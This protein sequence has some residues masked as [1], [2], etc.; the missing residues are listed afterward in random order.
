MYIVHPIDL[1]WIFDEM[2]FILKKKQKKQNIRISIIRGHMWAIRK[3]RWV[4]G[5]YSEFNIFHIEN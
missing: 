1:I 2:R 5:S 4:M 3:K